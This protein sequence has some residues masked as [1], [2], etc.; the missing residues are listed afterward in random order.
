LLRVRATAHGTIHAW[1]GK[2]APRS[3]SALSAGT[4][5][6]LTPELS[7]TVSFAK[8]RWRGDR[9]RTLLSCWACSSLRSRSGEDARTAC[10]EAYLSCPSVATGRARP[11]RILQAAVLLPRPHMQRPAPLV[12]TWPSMPRLRFQP[13]MRAESGW[14]RLLRLR[15]SPRPAL[16]GTRR[17]DRM[18]CSPS[19]TKRASDGSL[20]TF[21]TTPRRL[22]ANT[23]P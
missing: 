23:V 2:N 17:T 6:S 18:D 7:V 21:M 12:S 13:A 8:S 9:S 4:V 11:P 10:P 15:A 1:V 19:V 16:A 3:F 22:V 5:V 14:D 20:V